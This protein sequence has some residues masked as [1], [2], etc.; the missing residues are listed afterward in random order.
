MLKN[1]Q[2]IAISKYFMVSMLFVC[3]IFAAFGLNVDDSYAVE[4]NETG[5]ESPMEVNVEDTL[6]NSQENEV[7]EVSESDDANGMRSQQDSEVLSATYTVTGRT[8]KDIQNAIDGASSGDKIILNGNYSSKSGSDEISIDKKL[9]FVSTSSATL[10]GKGLSRIMYFKE[11]SDKSSI[12]NIR[13]INGNADYGGAILIKSDNMKIDNCIFEYNYAKGGGAIDTPNDHTIAKNTI[14][15]NCK[16]N[17]NGASTAAAGASL[18]GNNSKYINCIFFSNRVYN[19]NGGAFGGAMQIGADVSNCVGYVTNCTFINNS[20]FSRNGHS[21]GGAGCIRNGVI[22]S[23]CVFIN[24]S[25]DEGGAITYH[26]SGLIKNCVFINNSAEEYGGALSTGFSSVMKTLDLTIVNSTFSGN[27]AP[28]GGAIQL[29]GNNINLEKL[30]LN[31][32][33]ASVD[34][35]AINIEARSVVVTNSSF[36]SNIAEVDGGAIF[37]KGKSVV[38]SGSSFTNN[39]AIPDFDRYDEGLGGAIYVNSTNANINNNVFFFNTARNGSA[40]YYDK[41][42]EKLTV[43]NNVMYQN[44]AWVYWLP[45]YAKDIY[46]GDSENIGAVIHGGNN[47]AKYGDL[48][49]S[50]AI[51]N[52]ADYVKI[53][54]DGEYPVDGATDMGVLYQ[55]DREYNMNILLT[56]EKDDGTIIYNKSLNSD[57]LGEVSDEL[58]GLEP[59]KYYLTATHY[60]DTYYKGITNQTVFT[61][62]PVVDNKVRKGSPSDSFNYED[63]VVWTLNITN[64]GPNKA[65]DVVVTDVLPEGLIWVDDDSNGSYNPQ[66]GILNIPE[67][68]V[69]ETFIINIQTVVNKTGSLVNKVNVT[70]NE[71]DFDLSN[72]QAEKDINVLP[73][74]DVEVIK[75]VNNSSPKYL[76]MVTWTIVV[77]NNGPDVAHNVVVVD[78]LPESLIWISNT[79]AYDHESGL[80]EIDSLGSGDEMRINI[81][82]RVNATGIIENDVS[83]SADE[84]D[85]DKSNNNDSEIIRVNSATDLSIAKLANVTEANLTDYVKWTL[86]VTNNGPDDATGVIVHDILPEGFVYVGSK[87]Q[88]GTYSNGLINVGD[89]VSG[90]TVHLEIICKVDT[91]G[92]VTNYANVTGNEY[93]YDMTN[94][95]AYKSIIIKPACDLEVVK[96]V[97]ESAPKYGDYVLWT[98]TVFNHGPD[99]ATDVV[100]RDVL[101]Q[102]LIWV[103]DDSRGKYSHQSGIWSVGSLDCDDSIELNIITLVNATGIIQNNVSV[104]SAEFDYYM[105]NNKDSETI[106]I[107]PT[108]DVEITKLVNN[109]SPNYGDLII[110]TLIAKNNGPDKASDVIVED[111]LP[112]GLIVIDINATKGIYD[113]GRWVMCCLENGSAERLEIICKVNKTGVITNRASI[114]AEEVDPDL[115]NNDDEKAIRVPS[116]ADLEVAK[117]VSNQNP[118][119]GDTVT[120][121]ISIKNN[122]PDTATNVVLYDLLPEGMIFKRYSSTMGRFADG[123]WSVETLTKGQKEFLNITCTVGKLGI[124]VNEISANASEFDFNRSNNHASEYINTN[125]VIDLEVRNVVNNSNP[126]YKDMISLSVF[127]SNNGPNNAT[128]VK[129]CDVLPKG[130]TIVSSTENIGEDGIWNIGDLTVGDEKRLDVV[131]KITSTGNFTNVADVWGNEDEFNLDNNHDELEIHVAPA[132]DLSI[133]KTV[134]KYNY[135]RGDVVSYT[136]NVAN[137]G[138]SMAKNIRVSEVLDDSLALKSVKVSKGEFDDSNQFWSIDSLGAGEFATMYVK[139]LAKG[140]GLVKNAVS[141]T[142]ETEDDN[143]GNN[144][145]EVTVNVTSKN[146]DSKKPAEKTVIKHHYGPVI[147]STDK[148]VTKY[149]IKPIKDGLKSVSKTNSQ[150][151][152]KISKAGSVLS[153]SVETGN[154]L[155]VLVI[156]MLFSMVA[157]GSKILKRK[158]D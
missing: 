128:G 135:K 120:W 88:K 111:I 104:E 91:T 68:D 158:F 130:L 106:E 8:F 17:Y 34:G 112:E 21:H 90:E 89:L 62:N 139:A 38:I 49:V 94:N 40:I 43:S 137:R 124:I 56:V 41:Y 149:I 143:L 50:N 78:N 138:P 63:I 39:S 116:A 5:I 12:S 140:V 27:D 22:Y 141:V 156:S 33:H 36:E 45:I 79:G 28:L 108:A 146:K 153:K 23:D 1:I 125:P 114:S 123:I 76:D 35:G 20:A 82:C 48:A 3:L 100:V 99:T 110:W 29:I 97:N 7:Y 136:V 64:N 86:I 16:F 109:T 18:V 148:P 74:C 107:D 32:N 126:N 133:T 77:K 81:V 71:Y 95:H 142:S 57:Y 44:Q 55:D 53:Q 66:T 147:K 115:S 129:V 84:F 26:A 54:V 58:N 132:A 96:G 119:F 155:M 102:S 46:Y 101:P 98:V 103:D 59:G 150:S 6:E 145:D 113:D 37:I 15:S 118:S 87:L 131:F 67:L 31:D 47:I 117:N 93:D 11:G 134:T 83:V 80:W 85:Y 24:N 69:G 2:K 157:V 14:V 121:M 10:D 151:V 127:V 72:N 61:V 75:L 13:F 70:S 154:P 42:G 30:I 65:T 52:A 25:A 51:Y 9:T 4:L 19:T 122:G 105:D 144:H 92:E 152:K 73:A 60:E